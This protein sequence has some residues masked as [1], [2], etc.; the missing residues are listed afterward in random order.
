[1]TVKK[2][3]DDEYIFREIDEV[4]DAVL[5][6]LTAS[7]RRL[8]QHLLAAARASGCYMLASDPEWWLRFMRQKLDDAKALKEAIR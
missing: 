5:D 7:E 6:N 4:A 1:M 3:A 8:V 2:S